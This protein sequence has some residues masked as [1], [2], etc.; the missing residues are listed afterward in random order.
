M[1]RGTITPATLTLTGLS[2]TA[3]V[4][5]GTQV[6]VLAGASVLS[7]LVT[8]ES[9]TLIGTANGTLTSANA[10]SEAVTTAIT[11]GDGS[12]GLA[13][14]YTLTQPTLANVLIA[15]APLTLTGLTGTNRPY[16]GTTLDALTGTGALA[17][18]VGSQTLA[19]VHAS[20]GT[21][22]AADVGSQS[23]TTAIT[24]G[25]GTN[26]GVAANYVLSQTTL[27]NVTISPAMLTVSGTTVGNKIYDGGTVATLTGTLSGI[28]GADAVTLVPAGSF[29]SKDV[30]TGILVSAADTLSGAKAFDYTLTQ[31][32]GL[33]ANITPL[34]ITVSE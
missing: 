17:G 28:F 21:L 19:L 6:D 7:G 25:N 24:L 5:D 13:A 30:G 27:P 2:G 33:A 20:N 3:R 10:G 29:A 4:Y 31:P 12:G 22:G 26:G 16:N 32:T 23:L 18:L 11:L 9:L 14:N 1:G 15:Q 8:G 34:P